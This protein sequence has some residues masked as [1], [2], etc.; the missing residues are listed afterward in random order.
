MADLTGSEILGRALKN[1]GT[2]EF[3]FIMGG[4][5]QHAETAC[6]KEGIRMIDV[7]DKP[8]TRRS[9]SAMRWA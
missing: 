9:S 6:A 7:G 4:P 2:E 1:E 8:Q 5:M 3:F